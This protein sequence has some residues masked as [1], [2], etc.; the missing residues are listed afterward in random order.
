MK[1]N[2]E[3]GD[4]A[5][6]PV[7]MTTYLVTGCKQSTK[8]TFNVYK[9]DSLVEDELATLMANPRPGLYHLFF[10]FFHIA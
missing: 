4:G 1:S 2:Y 9:D 7:A 5:D 10:S 8:Y 3:V 6:E